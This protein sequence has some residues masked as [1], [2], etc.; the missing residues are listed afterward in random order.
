MTAELL[1]PVRR[2]R[3]ERAL[4]E[5]TVDRLDCLLYRGHAA[6]HNR[7]GEVESAL[8][9]LAEHG[10]QHVEKAIFA[11]VE[12]P[13]NQSYIIENTAQTSINETPPDGFVKAGRQNGCTDIEQERICP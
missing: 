2:R 5:G 10:R 12:E 6:I 3:L 4:S 1:V 13:P 9:L 8:A 7:Q 11:P